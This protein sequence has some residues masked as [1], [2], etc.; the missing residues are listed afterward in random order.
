MNDI[1]LATPALNSMPNSPTRYD[2]I[3]TSMPPPPP[4]N[5]NVS[6]WVYLFL[7]VN[8]FAIVSFPSTNR[9]R[10]DVPLSTASSRQR[11]DLNN[12][13]ITH[14]L[15]N[16]TN[17]IHTTPISTKTNTNNN[18]TYPN[19][20][21]QNL[22]HSH[23]H[24]HHHKP[25]KRPIHMSDHMAAAIELS[26]SPNVPPAPAAGMY[27]SR[28]LTYGRCPSRPLRAHSANLIGEYLYVFGG[29]D[30]KTCFNSLYVLDMGKS[31]FF[32]MQRLI[33]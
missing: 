21:Q 27:W 23:H 32:L 28:A 19:S 6:C 10:Q 20:N 15:S 2:Y 4:P 9:L 29:C 7:N 22:H 30:M 26:V 24:H 8:L 1:E 14:T 13:Q 33:E 18:S 25:S 5:S 3:D 16:N 11:Y 12:N 31:F 17:S